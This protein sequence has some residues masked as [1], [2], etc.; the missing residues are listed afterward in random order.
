MRRYETIT[1]IDPDL[2][3]ED[4]T[5]LCGQL[6]DR[7]SQEDGLLVEID[8][9]GNRKLAYEIKK[10]L[11]GHYVRLDYCGAGPLVDEMERYMR[12]TDGF[13]KYMTV[14]LDGEADLDKVKEE[15]AEREAAAE[16]KS[17]A[18]AERKAA[19]EASAAAKPDEAAQ[20]AAAEAPAA[21][22]TPAEVEAPAETEAPAEAE[23]PAETASEAP[24][25][26]ETEQTEQKPETEGEV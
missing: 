9:W 11:R 4:R 21:T 7:I 5:A 12:I 19:A 26:V 6:T 25:D 1:I 14:Q 24:V 8:D 22:E 3:E 13:L 20:T 23:A 16:A 18:E 2:A 17:K 15:I 10:K